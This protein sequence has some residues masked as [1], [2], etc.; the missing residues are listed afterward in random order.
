MELSKESITD[1]KRIWKE[2]GYPEIS[3]EEAN[4]IGVNLLQLIKL[5]IK[6]D[7]GNQKQLQ[8]QRFS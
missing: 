3:N 6:T 1:F 8:D 2:E 4:K 7:D 5:L